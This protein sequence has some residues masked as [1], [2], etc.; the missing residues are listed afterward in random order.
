MKKKTNPITLYG[1]HYFDKV[2][3]YKMKFIDHHFYRIHN[4]TKKYFEIRKKEIKDILHKKI[5]IKELIEKIEKNRK[6]ILSD[7]TKMILLNKIK[8]E[9]EYIKRFLLK[10]EYENKVEY[11]FLNNFE[12]DDYLLADYTSYLLSDHEYICRIIKYKFLHNLIYYNRYLE[13]DDIYNILMKE[14]RFR[15]NYIIYTD[16]LIKHFRIKKDDEI[17]KEII[18]IIKIFSN[19]FKNCT[20]YEDEDEDEDENM[21]M[22]DYYRLIESENQYI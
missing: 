5:K 16:K 19:Y 13:R 6:N 2:L 12:T 15:K 3:Y 14:K 7:K 4:L 8:N 11:K 21:T 17:F 10:E 22:D 20:E 18:N 9:V 1:V